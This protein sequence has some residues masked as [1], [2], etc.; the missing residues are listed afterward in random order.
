[1][2]TRPAAVAGTFYPA[3][4]RRLARAV[5]GLLDAV[6]VPAGEPAPAA[7]IVP[8]AGY[9]FSGPV[10]ASAYARIRGHPFRRVLVLGPAHFVPVDGL[11]VP[12]AEAF[13]TP[14]GPVPVDTTGLRVEV[15]DRAHTDEHSIEVQLPFLQRVLPPGW[16]L[17]PVAV[18]DGPASAVA[19]ALDEVTDPT[20]L[21]IVSTDLSH[22]QDADAA[23]RLDRATADAVVARDPD[24]LGDRSACGL[25]ALRGLL[26][27][28]G[29][30]DL[31]VHL[32]DLRNSADTAGNE[33]RVVGYGSFAVRP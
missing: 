3:S 10:A 25:F 13:Q 6:D 26:H 21:T 32:L 28:A 12:S 19:D 20:T 1:M 24:A 5:D 22:Y 2:G 9:R 29:R 27:W 4:P 18:G 11:A 14:L 16:T 30:R 8:H 7:L 15:C 31:A 17:A 33:S 23:R